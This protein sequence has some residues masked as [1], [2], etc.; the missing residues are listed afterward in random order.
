MRYALFYYE[1][2]LVAFHRGKGYK[3]TRKKGIRKRWR[4][5][6]NL[7]LNSQTD[8]M[9]DS[10]F[11]YMWVCVCSGRRRR[12]GF[13]Y[14]PHARLPSC[15]DV[16]LCCDTHNLYSFRRWSNGRW[17]IN[18]SARTI[19]FEQLYSFRR[20]FCI[21]F[22]SSVKTNRPKSP[23]YNESINITRVIQPYVNTNTPPYKY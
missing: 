12:K 4:Q 5:Y 16:N 1:F 9:V 7:I 23:D 8:C 20:L 22:Y 19:Y 15:R 14:G 21:V 6:F 13:V 11:I 18:E 10:V 3:Y 17:K 2:L